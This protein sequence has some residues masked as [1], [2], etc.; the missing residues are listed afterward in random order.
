MFHEKHSVFLTVF[1]R[2]KNI[3]CNQ[4]E[5]AK[6]IKFSEKLKNLQQCKY[7]HKIGRIAT[8]L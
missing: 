3:L 4:F 1:E 7:Y 2:G 6:C 5:M 8:P